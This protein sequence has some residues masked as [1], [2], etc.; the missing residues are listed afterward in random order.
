M[1]K[2]KKEKSIWFWIGIAFAL[3]VV[4]LFLFSLHPKHTHSDMM[5]WIR[6]TEFFGNHSLKDFYVEGIG[7]YTPGY[8][9]FLKLASIILKIC[10]ASTDGVLAAFCYQLPAII[11]DVVSG[12]MIYICSLDGTSKGREFGIKLALLYLFNPAVLFLSIVFSQIDSIYTLLIVSAIYFLKKRNIWMMGLLLAISITFKLQTLFAGPII[13]LGIFYYF[14]YEKQYLRNGIRILLAGGLSFLVMGVICYPFGIQ[15]TWNRCILTLGQYPYCG[16]NAANLWGL[17]GL[18]YVEQS[19][20]F[21]GIPYVTYG[22]CLMIV[23]VVGNMYMAWKRRHQMETTYL[24]C[25]L[26]FI[27]IYMVSVRM[28]ERY[29]FPG[30]LL[31]LAAVAVSKDTKYLVYYYTYSLLSFINFACVIGLAAGHPDIYEPILRVLSLIQIVVS[32]RLVIQCV[33]GK[34]KKVEVFECLE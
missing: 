10:K 34:E 19:E 8:L 15:N 4:L 2:Q 12:Y 11:C 29:I 13:A 16:L 22:W 31:L 3:R 23:V 1:E 21:L 27:L 18:N 17:L 33:I 9:Y 30:L 28:H 20:Q 14:I 7:D 6:W 24:M 26:N 25:A 5:Y 32:I